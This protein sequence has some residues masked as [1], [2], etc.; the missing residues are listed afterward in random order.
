VE[1]TLVEYG[2]P[3]FAGRDDRVRDPDDLR[4]PRYGA[5]P[6]RAHYEEVE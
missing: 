4:D 2:T 3:R 6:P 1:V 5:L